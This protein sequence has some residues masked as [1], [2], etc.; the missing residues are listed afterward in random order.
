MSTQNLEPSY[1]EWLQSIKERIRISRVKAALAANSELIGFYWDLGKMM[2]AISDKTSWG[3]NWVEQM[4][5]DLQK[6]FPDMDGFSKTN[7]YNIRRLYLF[8]LDDPIFHQLG[9]KIPWRHHVEIFS[10]AKT[11]P[12]AHFYIKQTI[13]NGWSRDVLALQIKSNLH[14]RQGNAVTNFT[15][16]LPSPQSEMAIQTMKDPYLFDFLSF[17]NTYQEKDIENQLISHITKFLLELGKG[18]AYIGRQYHLH[19]GETDYYIDL[20]FYHVKLRCYFDAVV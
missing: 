6:E 9:G 14:S 15:N 16:T 8:Y 1:A 10:K 5:K 19:I 7:L 17:T 18:F 3:N 13:E 4:S 12:E 20:L 11:L 2:T